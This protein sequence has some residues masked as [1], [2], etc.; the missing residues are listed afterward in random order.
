M[1]QRKCKE[2]TDS[3]VVRTTK[4]DHRKLSSKLFLL[5]RVGRKK[6]KAKAFLDVKKIL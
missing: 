5:E 3:I 1:K 2:Q 4:V 6:I